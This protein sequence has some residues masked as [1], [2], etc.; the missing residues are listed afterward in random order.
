MCDMNISSSFLWS[1]G[2]EI[3]YLWP[4]ENL[5]GSGYFPPYAPLGQEYGA[6][7]Y[8]NSLGSLQKRNVFRTRV[9]GHKK[10]FIRRTA[11]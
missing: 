8:I 7:A 6:R 3:Q 5:N 9:I 4:K 1:S 2:F 11:R 10:T